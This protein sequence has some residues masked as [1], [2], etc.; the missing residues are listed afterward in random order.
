[1]QLSVQQKKLFWGLG[2]VLAMV[3]VSVAWAQ[4]NTSLSHC[5]SSF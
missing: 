3:L 4:I 2:I 5:F 1:M